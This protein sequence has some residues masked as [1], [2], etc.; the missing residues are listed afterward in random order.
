MRIHELSYAMAIK[1]NHSPFTYVGYLR[2]ATEPK[3]F[4]YNPRDAAFYSMLH[5]DGGFAAPSPTKS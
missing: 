3:S 1:I 5:R 4:A 2:I